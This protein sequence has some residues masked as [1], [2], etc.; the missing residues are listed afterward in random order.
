MKKLLLPFILIALS[1]NAQQKETVD[2]KWKISDTLTYKTVMRNIVLEKSEEQTENDSIS[3][4]MSG[5]FKAMQEQLSNLKYETKLFPDKNGNV[6]IA[7]MLKKEKADTTKTLFS[8]MAKMNGNVVLRGKVSPDGELLS[9]Y[10]KSAQNNLI[11]ILFELPTKPVSIGDQ[12]EVKVDM[13]SMDQNFKADTLSKK[14]VVKLKDIKSDNGKKIAVVEYDIEEFVSGDF[15][16]RI[17]NMFSKNK[18]DKKTFMRMSHK[19]I[20]EFDLEKGYWISYDGIMDVETN[21]SLMG[22][23]GNKRTEF[24]LTPE[25]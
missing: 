13:I 25:K 19:A 16:N 9:F 17:M 5:M 22:M 7:M 15:G 20:A 3:K 18:A 4:K 23:G 14:N 24:K 21:F 10:Y 6:D 1:L 12:W 8:G 11:S 2:L